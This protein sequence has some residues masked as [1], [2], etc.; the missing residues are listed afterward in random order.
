M[1]VVFPY[2]RL[3]PQVKVSSTTFDYLRV[4]YP[5]VKRCLN[6]Q[7]DKYEVRRLNLLQILRDRCEG[8]ASV[9]AARLDR[10]AS[11]VSR[12]LYEEGKAGKKRIGE[13]MAD[14]IERAFELQKSALDTEPS[15]G[16]ELEAQGALPG[17]WSELTRVDAYERRILDLVRQLDERAKGDAED[18]LKEIVREYKEF[19][20]RASE[21]TVDRERRERAVESKTRRIGAVESPPERK[22]KS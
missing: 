1:Q 16:S 20:F 9:L 15:A 6:A 12:M 8:K 19:T 21:S 4:I 3:Y 13:D 7:M 18:E 14:M 5:Q 2:P 17:G 11:Y 22:R 10:S